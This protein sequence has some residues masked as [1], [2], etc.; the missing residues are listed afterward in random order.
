MRQ[1][2]TSN[3]CVLV[4]EGAV[5]REKEGPISNLEELELDFEVGRG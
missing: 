4:H 3:K 5:Y 1:N 2:M